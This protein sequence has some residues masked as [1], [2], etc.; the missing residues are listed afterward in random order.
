MKT[1]VF[2][3]KCY[4]SEKKKQNGCT[5]QISEWGCTKTPISNQ[6]HCTIQKCWNQPTVNHKNYLLFLT[7]ANETAYPVEPVTWNGATYNRLD[8]ATDLF[9]KIAP[10]LVQEIESAKGRVRNRGCF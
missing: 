9:G 8:A 2:P 7:L 6:S 10:V 1:Y 3:P 4:F 5:T